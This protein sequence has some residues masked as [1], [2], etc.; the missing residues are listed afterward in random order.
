[1]NQRA[2]GYSTPWSDELTGD[3]FQVLLVEASR[4]TYPED[5]FGLYDDEP[6][7]LVIRC[8][9][10]VWVAFTTWGGQY[11]AASYDEGIPVAYRIDDGEVITQHRVGDGFQ[12]RSMGRRR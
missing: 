12:R 5:E 3:Q 4:Y 2:C 11:V 9:E 8:D 6:P 10:G 7:Y 1:M